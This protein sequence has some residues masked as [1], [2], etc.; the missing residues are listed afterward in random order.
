ME[1]FFDERLVVPDQ[2]LTLMQGAI[3]PWAK[4]KSPYFTQTIDAMSKHYGFDKKAKWKD[5]PEKVKDLF[6]HGSGGEEI[7]FRYDEGGRIYQVSRVFEGV[8][9][10]M[11]RRYRETDS[12]I[13]REDLGRYRN[14][15]ACT[16]CKGT[17][18]RREARHVRIGEGAQSRAIFD[19]SH[20]TLGESQAYF[21]RKNTQRT[22]ARR[23]GAFA[24]APFRF[25]RS[26][27]FNRR[28][29]KRRSVH[30]APFLRGASMAN[31]T[32]RKNTS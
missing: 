32:L 13:V 6:L 20:I 19:I 28:W 11:E 22:G 15:Q 5:L 25:G 10:N 29:G 23:R 21:Q 18:L 17:R 14:T 3:A 9:P 7:A 24:R 30:G 12:S 4:S 2:G 1:L 27:R 16:D 31:W 26:T 8:I